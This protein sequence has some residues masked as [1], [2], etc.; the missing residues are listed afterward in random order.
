MNRE[1]SAIEAAVDKVLADG[2]RTPDI[3]EEGAT[4]AL[5]T[6]EMGQRIVDAID[7]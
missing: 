3:A 1:A 4:S 6:T 5:T 2:Y 7:L